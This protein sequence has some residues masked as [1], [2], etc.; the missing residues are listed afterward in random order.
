MTKFYNYLK[1]SKKYD[2]EWALEF[3]DKHWMKGE[4][5]DPWYLHG[6]RNRKDLKTGWHILCT[7]YIHK[8]TTYAS[9]SL[10]LIA[11]KK[12]TKQMDLS[13]TNTKHMNKLVRM[14]IEDFENDNLPFAD[15]IENTIG[16]IN[17]EALE[18]VIR[19]E[20]SPDDIVNAA[21]A[22]DNGEWIEWFNDRTGDQIDFVHVPDG[23]ILFNPKKAMTIKLPDDWEERI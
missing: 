23:A 6:R 12:N 17:K 8:A 19:D 22:W 20:F 4:V 21:Q 14:A 11:P 13:G 9:G 18:K 2:E 5:P 3:I 1:E 15:D 7:K 16:Y 10:W